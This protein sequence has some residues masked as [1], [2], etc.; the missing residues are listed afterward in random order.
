MHRG[1][2]P[3]KRVQRTTYLVQNL[4]Q[5]HAPVHTPSVLVGSK[6]DDHMLIF[7]VVAVCMPGH[8]AGV[9]RWP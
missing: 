9:L 8:S 1:K 4:V 7:V 6:L 2:L 5:L 3:Q